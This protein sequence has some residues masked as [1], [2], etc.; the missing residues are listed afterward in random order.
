MNTP[1]GRPTTLRRAEDAVIVGYVRSPFTLARNG[2]LARTRP[3]DIA[4]QVIKAL[5]DRSG[6]PPQN[7]DDLIC[8]C[9]FPEGEQ[10]LN[11]GRML[12]FLAGLPA[13]VTGATVNR[14]CGSSM[15]AAHW[16][17]GSIA[18]ASG[19]AFIVAGVESMSR[20]PA[21]GFN[22]L[23]HPALASDQPQVLTAMG[24][25][26]E[27][28]A[29]QF[30]ISRA[31]QEQFAVASHRKA[32]ASRTA[33]HFADE[34]VTIQPPQ[35]SAITEDGCIRP[36][37]SSES[38]AALKPAFD[39]QGTVTAGTASPL[40]DGAAAVLVTS[41]RFAEAHGLPPLAR[42]LTA[43]VSGCEPEMMGL[44][45]IAASRKALDRAG[46]TMA[47]M[48]LVELNEAFAAPTI[49]CCRM[50][51]IDTRLL[52]IDGGAL[53]IG[54][55]LGATGARLLGKAASLLQRTGQRY[56]LATQCIGGGQ[57][58][59]TILEHENA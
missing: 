15:Q 8:G 57:G 36:G 29:R 17:A 4:A 9:A 58:I 46:L 18:I 50:L 45:P 34:L 21:L 12:V 32:E 47:D 16:A 25:T 7:I 2:A 6:L 3:D 13:S 14:W 20:I 41:R 49:A 11:L 37:T 22:P 38:L 33:G 54:H 10:G 19:E 53:A 24:I 43:A 26:A 44:G 55:P 56:A 23:P 28:V 31:E 42:I 30:D 27:N 51:G 1:P 39:A 59:A 5:V 40:T 35:G 48:D 52:N